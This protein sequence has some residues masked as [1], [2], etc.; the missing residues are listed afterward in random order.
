[1]PNS[2]DL[3]VTLPDVLTLAYIKTRKNNSQKD[4]G[5]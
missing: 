2:P 4:A 5:D 3:G 1:M